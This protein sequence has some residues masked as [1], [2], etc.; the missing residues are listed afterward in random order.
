[1][2][3]TRTY[4]IAIVVTI[5]HAKNWFRVKMGSWWS[6][7]IYQTTKKRKTLPEKRRPGKARWIIERTSCNRGLISIL[8]G[9]ERHRWQWRLKGR[10]VFRY[11]RF[12]FVA[13]VKR[14]NGKTTAETA[15]ERCEKTNG[16][17]WTGRA[18]FRVNAIRGW[19]LWCC[20]SQTTKPLLDFGGC[21]RCWCCCCDGS[22]RNGDCFF[23]VEIDIRS[24]CRC[25][26][27]WF[28]G[29]D[30]GGGGKPR[31]PD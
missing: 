1:M 30:R 4:I 9:E 7:I 26:G 29:S 14:T 19:F 27:C 16:P 5:W 10:R 13:C 28:R 23:F 24:S 2:K 3:K 11:T 22:L 31:T 8:G 18:F 25:D 21:M 17:R 15:I 20:P 6:A 12:G